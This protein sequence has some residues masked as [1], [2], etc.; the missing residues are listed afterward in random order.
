ML[1]LRVSICCSNNKIRK[2]KKKE[3]HKKGNK[4]TNARTP[5][6]NNQVKSFRNFSDWRKKWQP[7]PLFF[8]GEFHGQ[9]RPEGYS[10]WGRKES[11]MTE[12][13]T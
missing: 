13:L 1:S 12:Q 7:T 6:T 2:K 5:D 8:P 9:G 4:K 3:R 10:P 11:D